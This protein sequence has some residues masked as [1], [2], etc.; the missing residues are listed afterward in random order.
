MEKLVNVNDAYA[1]SL[2]K[3]GIVENRMK[4]AFSLT[5]AENLDKGGFTEGL[6]N[7]Y[8]TII[9]L[10]NEN[11]NTLERLGRIYK[12][13]FEGLSVVVKVATQWFASFLR[14]VESVG[15][16]IGW[17]VDNPLAGLLV[18]IPLIAKNMSLLAKVM[19]AAFKTPLMILTLII[20]ALDE[21]RA[22]F[23]DDV[24]GLFD[25]KGW[26]DE[27]SKKVHAQRRMMMGMGSAEDAK[28]ATGDSILTNNPFYRFGE[29]LGVNTPHASQTEHG[30]TVLAV[31]EG[32]AKTSWD[33]SIAA[34]KDYTSWYSQNTLSNQISITINSPD[35]EKA[36]ESV[37]KELERMTGMQAAGAR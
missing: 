16:T 22:Y 25:D 4:S 24:V 31:L 9:D 21:I 14:A 37:K 2:D 36:G 18:G 6:K 35:P 30:S 29:Q 32:F 19:G 11:T 13:V 10:V 20:G 8:K 12:K 15:Q 26:S 27:K 3:L 7:F 23:D 5:A 28:L 1:K 33:L 17:F 34:L